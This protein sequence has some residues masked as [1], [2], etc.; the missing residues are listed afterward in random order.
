[1]LDESDREA[2][3]GKFRWYLRQAR[4]GLYLIENGKQRGGALYCSNEPHVDVS[5]DVLVQYSAVGATIGEDRFYWTIS[6]DGFALRISSA[7][8]QGRALFTSRIKQTWD[9]GEKVHPVG[10]L[11]KIR[12]RAKISGVGFWSHSPNSRQNHQQRINGRSDPLWTIS[13]HRDMELNMCH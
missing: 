11:L 7:L 6:H 10:R 8:F 2:G 12:K 3:S 9:R 13:K 1:M 4:S 5:S